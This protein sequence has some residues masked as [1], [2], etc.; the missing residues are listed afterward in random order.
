MKA[1][2]RWYYDGRFEREC[3]AARERLH[4]PRRTHALLRRA[5]GEL[6]LVPFISEPAT[7]VGCC[8]MP[9]VKVEIEF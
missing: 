5:D 4:E 2:R 8:L 9:D 3:A 6:M 1:D 7:L